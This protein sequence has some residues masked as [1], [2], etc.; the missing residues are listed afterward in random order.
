MKGL[1]YVPRCSYGAEPVVGHEELFIIDWN[2]LLAFGSEAV[3]PHCSSIDRMGPT[4]VSRAREQGLSASIEIC[5]DNDTHLLS[6][7][8]SLPLCLAFSLASIL[9]LFQSLFL[10]SF[11]LSLSFSL[12]R[13]PC[14]GLILMLISS[15]SLCVCWSVAHSLVTLIRGLSCGMRQTSG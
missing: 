8:L 9:F 5:F 7:S 13:F 10:A 11:S 3:F 12:S 6:T 14:R 15:L 4:E 2:I 1:G